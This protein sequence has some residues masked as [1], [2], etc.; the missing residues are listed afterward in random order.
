MSTSQC[1]GLWAM[2]D[3]LTGNAIPCKPPKSEVWLPVHMTLRM[4]ARTLVRKGEA[5]SLWAMRTESFI[6]HQRTG[7]F[8]LASFG[9]A[10]FTGATPF[11][12]T[13]PSLQPIYSQAGGWIGLYVCLCTCMWTTTCACVCFWASLD[14]IT[15]WSHSNI[16]ERKTEEGRPAL[17]PMH[18]PHWTAALLTMKPLSLKLGVFEM[19]LNEKE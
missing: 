8:L 14:L 19:V 2:A 1:P 4:L 18:T 12:W 11:P 16:S 6:S 17:K 5:C 7:Q 3:P 9:V 13:H 15:V 10:P